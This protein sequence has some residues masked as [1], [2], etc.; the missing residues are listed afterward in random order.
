MCGG[1]LCLEFINYYHE[2]YR[3]R[4]VN[5]HA[6]VTMDVEQ[7]ASV[8]KTEHNNNNKFD[9][10][11]RY[12]RIINYN[13]SLGTSSLNCKY[14]IHYFALFHRSALSQIT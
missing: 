7:A 2:S 11:T 12:Y 5:V 6:T 14:K 13:T 3:I 10:K 4:G 9:Q 8:L 1:G